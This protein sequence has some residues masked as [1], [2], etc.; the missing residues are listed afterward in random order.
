VGG[1]R[2]WLEGRRGR[3]D[4]MRREGRGMTGREAGGHRG[5]RWGLRPPMNTR[6]TGEWKRA[7]TCP[8]V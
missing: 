1:E 2:L 5:R 7:G 4:R 6:K 3:R 8:H